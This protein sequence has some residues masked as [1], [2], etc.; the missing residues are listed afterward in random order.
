M[1]TKLATV[2]KALLTGDHQLIAPLPVDSLSYRSPKVVGSTVGGYQ[3]RNG[4]APALATSALTVPAATDVAGFIG[5]VGTNALA[6]DDTARTTHNVP[7]PT[8]P[9]QY[10]GA[11]A[12]ND[13]LVIDCVTM[14]LSAAVTPNTPAGWGSRGSFHNGV[15][16]VPK[17][18]RFFK[19]AVGGETG[20]LAITTSSSVRMYAYSRAIRGVDTSNYF[21]VAAPQISYGSG[22]QSPDPV[23]AQALVTPGSLMEVAVHG[24]VY[25]GGNPE[26]EDSDFSAGFKP[27]FDNTHLAR[28][29]AAGEKVLTTVGQT[30]NP[31][32]LG[33]VCDNYAAL[34]DVYRVKK[35][36]AAGLVLVVA[37]DDE[38]ASSTISTVPTIPARNEKQTIIS[39][40][41]SGTFTITFSGQTT[42][43]IA[44]NASAA[45][46]KTALENLSNIGAGDINATGGP[47][48]TNQVVIEF[49]NAMAGADQPAMTTNT[50]SVT[51]RQDQTGAAAINFFAMG[52]SNVPPTTSPDDWVPQI[53][54]WGAIPGG[55]WPAGRPVDI[56]VSDHANNHSWA[57]ALLAV[58]DL[59]SGGMI[60][61][62]GTGVA[63]IS[64][65]VA[66][67]GTVTPTT[68]GSL[69]LASHAKALNGATWHPLGGPVP[70][71]SS[72]ARYTQV[73]HAEADA[74]TLDVWVSQPAAS[75]PEH[76]SSITWAGLENYAN[77]VASLRP[78]VSAG[79][80][81]AEDVL[82]S[83]STLTWLELANSVSE[84]YEVFELDLDDI[85]TGAALT[86]ASIRFAHSSDVLNAL[87]VTLV[88]IK[89]DGTFV[90]A[91]ERRAGGYS[92]QT[93]NSVE[94]VTTGEWFEFSDGSVIS[95][96]DRL[97]VLVFSTFRPT[98]L[99]THK[100]YWVQVDVTYEAGGP[101]VA[102]V[103]GVNTPGDSITW[104]YSSAAGLPQS[105]YRALVVQ[106]ADWDL[107]VQFADYFF[108]D[109]P[110]PGAGATVLPSGTFE[111]YDGTG[112]AGFGRRRPSAIAVVADGTASGGNKLQITASN[113]TGG[114]TGQLV[115][116]GLKIKLPITYGQIE[117]RAK[118][119]GDANNFLSPVVLLW[120]TTDETRF[121]TVDGGV[122]PAGGEI[123][124]WENFANRDDLNPIESHIHRLKPG[125]VPVYDSNDDEFLDF[126]WTG[127]AGT[128]WHKYVLNW[129]PTGLYLSIDDGA[130]V[131]L[132]EDPDWVPDWPMELCIQFDAWVNGTLGANRT[133]DVDYVVLRKLAVETLPANPLDP[134]YGE[135][136][137]D[138]GKVPSS[139][140]RS[141]RTE[142]APLSRGACTALVRS[143]A[144]LPNGVEVASRW[145]ID[146]SFDTSGSPATSGAQ[147]TQP[148]FNAATAAMELSLTTP[149]AVSRAWLVRSIDAGVTWT[150]V[151]PFDVG[152]GIPVK[153]I[154][155]EVPLGQSV[156][157]QVSFDAGPM[158]ETS[159]PV[160]V[161]SGGTST[162]ST[163]WWLR[164]P[165][166][167]SMS[168]PI[169]VIETQD[170]RGFNTVVAEDVEHAV[171]VGSPPLSRTMKLTVRTGSK[172]EREKVDAILDSGL[173]F[174]VVNI[175]GRSWK[176]RLVG[177]VVEQFLRWQALPSEVTKLR[178]AYEISFTVVEVKT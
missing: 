177:D 17:V 95:D 145:G 90:P 131:A 164:V 150:L 55:T 162:V 58:R 22:S 63:D 153:L 172:A 56:T 110:T 168:T 86:S 112:N 10:G 142:D 115:S 102:N 154:D 107:D 24:N 92:T 165:G 151:G 152:A 73:A 132:T 161:G 105:H 138:S 8:V 77:H 175:L 123:N 137:Y 49:V 76:L 13:L 34:S 38:T 163:S 116:G 149:A 101:I 155:Y 91:L 104:D 78:Q 111:L 170:T 121:P 125:A 127:V 83:Q 136:V 21:D 129:L 42:A 26:Y 89:A 1:S 74:M 62:Y 97:G 178:D 48:G 143:W 167:P 11:I 32:P 126:T 64:E 15:A 103:Q 33:I 59:F 7:Y 37:L 135:I 100:L 31:G 27:V 85:P 5:T 39:N 158:T 140:A 117:F 29:S 124:I 174:E 54:Y 16:W 113:G 160:A 12:A 30:D 18:T 25:P 52:T 23:A 139:T 93:V 70:D 130:F 69:I 159:A 47:L 67:F 19:M 3:G 68:P 4:T 57:A 141:A 147:S 36:A 40:L 88:G 81:A 80:S 133:M 173:T 118:G 109:F 144:R 14:D 9:A 119:S 51:I 94:E 148:V 35:S 122:W 72:P 66:I 50:G 53:W 65:Q 156:R 99:T 2:P 120:P 6:W 106:G 128:A 169:T 61:D 114:D 176:V 60:Q 146:E 166:T 82:A 157:Y 43:A 20:T 134:Q 87:R 45:T 108:T 96:Y 41:T 79:T 84:L 98:T 44:F 75:A 28:W 71:V 46:I 171:V